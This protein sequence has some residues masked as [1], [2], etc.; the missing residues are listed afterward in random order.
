MRTDVA[1]RLKR[2]LLIIVAII[3]IGTVGYKLIGG[4]KT[5]LLDALYMTAITITTVGYEDFIGAGASTAGK[6]FTTVYLFLSVGTIFYL[7]T[8]LASYMVEGEVRKVFRRRSMERR[9]DKMRNHYIVCGI[10]MV[11]L[12]IVHELYETKRPQI[13][14]DSEPAQF[15]LL[16]TR[17]IDVP[18]LL[19][20]ATENELLEKAMVREARG[21]FA[22]TNSDND[23]IVIA[24][25]AKQ[26]NPAL[27][28]VCRCNDTK[29]IDKIKRAGADTVVALNYIGG[30]RMAAEMTRPHATDFLE[31]MLRDKEKALRV[32]EVVVPAGSKYVGRDI[33]ALELPNM[34]NILLLAVRKDGG[35]W[36]Y[37]PPASLTLEKDMHLIVL[38]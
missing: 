7:F 13:A 8:A 18:V 19:G 24:L 36:V 31:S 9:I 4:E 30:L 29:N 28:V 14:I 35:E 34:G 15:D 2:M 11:G 12:Y 23:N 22:T 21:L 25:T 5:T 27:R 20:D 37:N 10:G 17:N 1:S 33:E 32:E 26:L 6:V 3:C 38:A 16:K